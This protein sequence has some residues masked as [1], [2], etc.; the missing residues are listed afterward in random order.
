MPDVLSTIFISYAHA[1]SPFVDRLEA[2]LRQRGFAPRV[3]RQGLAGGQKWR[4]E[5]QEA[6]DRADVVLVVLSPEAVAS[7][8]VQN[9]YGYA[10]EES[11]FQQEWA[12]GAAFTQDEA[13]DYA[14]SSIVS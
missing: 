14:L 13:I 7:E 12:T 3:D 2:D 5:L 10:G 9:E 8:Y 4:R 1:D 6:I 11:A